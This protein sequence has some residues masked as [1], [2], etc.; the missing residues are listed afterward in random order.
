MFADINFISFVA[1]VHFEGT[2]LCIKFFL[3]FFI[4]FTLSILACDTYEMNSYPPH[5]RKCEKKK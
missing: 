1:S 3:P 2:I 5:Q 4:C